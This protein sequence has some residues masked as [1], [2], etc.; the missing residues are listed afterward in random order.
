M[1]IVTVSQNVTNKHCTVETGRLAQAWQAYL[2]KHGSNGDFVIVHGHDLECSVAHGRQ[3]DAAFWIVTSP[4]GCAV[5]TTIFGNPSDY[6]GAAIQERYG[7][8][9]NCP[10]GPLH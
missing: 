10:G 2:T 8:A 1:A 6:I 7:G 5:F 9:G 3:F 4:R